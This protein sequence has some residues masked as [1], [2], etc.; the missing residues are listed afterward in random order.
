MKAI[1]LTD[2]GMVRP[3]NED[4]VYCS[5]QQVGELPNLFVVADGMGGEQAGDEASRLAVSELIRQIEADKRSNAVDVLRHAISNINL[6]IY[7]EAC[8]KEEMTGMGTTL[9]SA[10]IDHG[11]LYIANIGDSRLYLIRDSIRQ[12]THDHSYVEEMVSRGRMLK[13]SDD[14]KKNRNILTRA[15]GT[16]QK[17]TADFFDEELK[18]G[19]RILLCTDGLTNL[20]EDEEIFTVIRYTSSLQ[21][22]AERLVKMANDHGGTDNISVVLIDYDGSEEPS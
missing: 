14:Y 4:T 1:A 16:Q 8:S 6:I 17:I 12:L 15:L 9:V 5:V 19:D 7:M 10:V 20:L 13:G 11:T 18:A 2:R 22:A 21:D 3:N